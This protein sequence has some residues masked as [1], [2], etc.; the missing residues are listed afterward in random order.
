[1]KLT[2][3]VDHYV[4]NYSVQLCF[5]EDTLTFTLRKCG[6]NDINDEMLETL[7]AFAAK[8]RNCKKEESDAV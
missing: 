3:D 4:K 8:F 5:H 7:E 6:I 1:M 2:T